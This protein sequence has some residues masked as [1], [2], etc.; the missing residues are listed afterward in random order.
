MV[1]TVSNSTKTPLPVRQGS[2]MKEILQERLNIYTNATACAHMMSRDVTR[3]SVS[4]NR[5]VAQP[6]WANI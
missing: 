2:R 3:R 5:K 6:H 1:L 4:T